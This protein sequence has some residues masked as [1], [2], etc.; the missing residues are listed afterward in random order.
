MTTTQ[1]VNTKVE[2]L[3]TRHD[4]LEDTVS[5]AMERICEE[6]NKANDIHQKNFEQTTE[7]NKNM[8]VMASE[9][10]EH[11]KKIKETHDQ[12]KL[13]TTFINRLKGFF[14]LSSGASAFGFLYVIFTKGASVAKVF[15]P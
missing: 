9:F 8:A 13:N 15:I 5:S 2:V 10:E 11:K 7:L 3:K 6:L 1:E 4:N 12:T 14:I